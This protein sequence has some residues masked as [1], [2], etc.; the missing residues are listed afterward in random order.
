MNYLGIVIVL[1]YYLY[2]YL[3]IGIT[4]KK[5]VEIRTDNL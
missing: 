2:I 3:K 1:S 4:R 5:D